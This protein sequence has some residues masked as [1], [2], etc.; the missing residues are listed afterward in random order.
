MVFFDSGSALLDWFAEGT[1]DAA[2]LWIRY[3]HISIE[4]MSLLH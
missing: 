2:M 4:G 1:V 3:V